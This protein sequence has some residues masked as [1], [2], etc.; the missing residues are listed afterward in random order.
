LDEGRIFEPRVGK[1]KLVEVGWD[2]GFLWLWE[3]AR[4]S[5]E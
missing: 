1:F 3:Y 5:N 4:R 2:Y